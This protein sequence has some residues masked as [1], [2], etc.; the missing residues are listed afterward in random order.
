MIVPKGEVK[1][2]IRGLNSKEFEAMI[3]D[4]HSLCPLWVTRGSVKKIV[5]KWSKRNE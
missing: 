3:D 2:I 1:R 5:M 4:I